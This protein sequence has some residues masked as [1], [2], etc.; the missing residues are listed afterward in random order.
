M[1][2]KSI[3]KKGV[4]FG[5]LLDYIGVPKRAGDRLPDKGIILHN[6]ETTQADPVALE[7]EF[8]DNHRF[9]R[10]RRNGVTCFHEIL[11][12]KDPHP[13]MIQILE[14]L[15]RTYLQYRAPRAL[16]YGQIHT[17]TGH[18]HL[19]LLISGN[20]IESSKKIRISK[21]R[22]A[23]IKQKLE[24]YQERHYPFLSHSVVFGSGKTK[25]GLTLAQTQIH[26]EV[27]R[28]LDRA[29][30]Q[31]S[32]EGLLGQAGMQFYRRGKSVGIKVIR[33]GKKY[34]FKTLGLLAAF[35]TRKAQWE[36]V[37]EAG[38]DLIVQKKLEKNRQR[39]IHLII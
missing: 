6:L 2:V 34:R 3:S 11:S 16:A 31:K 25:K 17:E 27:L 1:I 15:G 18:P 32:F 23:I 20:E 35:Q 36:K 4:C 39:G 19:H 21:K 7:R 33:T 10:A 22:F 5:K 8:L 14:D 24:R 28:Y 9:V 13:Q 12:L 38:K 29:T 30:T 26:D 37:Q